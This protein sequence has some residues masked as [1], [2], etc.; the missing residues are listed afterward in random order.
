[1]A[2]ALAT[3]E[4]ARDFFTAGAEREIVAAR[5][6]V[7]YYSYM[8]LIKAF[9][10]TRGT[11]TSVDQAQH[12]LKERIRPGGRELVDAYLKVDASR[13]QQQPASNFAEFTQVLTGQPLSA[14]VEYDV[15]TLMAQ[16]LPGHR[17]WARATPEARA[18][19]RISRCSVLV[20]PCES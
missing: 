12:G 2:E 14:A 16:I 9:C 1:M 15:A 7:L 18:L 17:H 8:N 20:R 13:N 10:L 19:Y 3:L 11:R 5:P 4:Q 6:L